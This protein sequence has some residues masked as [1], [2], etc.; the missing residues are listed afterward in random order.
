M[1]RQVKVNCCIATVLVLQLTSKVSLKYNRNMLFACCVAGEAGVN[2]HR[3]VWVGGRGGHMWRGT[4][5][6]HLDT[7]SV[8]GSV[9]AF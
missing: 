6:K 4:V 1:T 2:P 7:M 8:K 5:I 3:E 9:K